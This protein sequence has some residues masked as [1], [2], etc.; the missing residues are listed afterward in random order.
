MSNM[1][2]PNTARQ[3]RNANLKL[4]VP[5]ESSQFYK[6]KVVLLVTCLGNSSFLSL[7]TGLKRLEKAGIKLLYIQ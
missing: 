2:N 3:Q 5:S 1:S 7:Y 6:K 4:K